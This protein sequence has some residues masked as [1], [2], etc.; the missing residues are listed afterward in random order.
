MDDTSVIVKSFGMLQIPFDKKFFNLPFSHYETLVENIGYSKVMRHVRNVLMH[1]KDDEILA[2]KARTL[3]RLLNTST[4][5][6]SKDDVKS[7]DE[8]ECG[9]LLLE[10]YEMCPVCGK[11]LY[12]GDDCYYLLED[13]ACSLDGDDCQ[14]KSYKECG[15]CD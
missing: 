6:E 1:Y 9:C 3:I 2:E 14:W 5:N 8:C 4:L 10:D 12:S 15:K 7:E 11:Q 13:G